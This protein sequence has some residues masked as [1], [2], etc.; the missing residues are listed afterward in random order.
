MKMKKTLALVMTAT[1]SFATLTGCSKTTNNY[2]DELAKKSEWKNVSSEVSGK[3]S[4]QSQ[5]ITKN[6]SFTSTG[7]V[8][9]NKGYANVKLTDESGVY[10]IPEINAYTDGATTYINKS[11]YEG[12]YTMMGQDVPEELKNIN[13]EYIAIDSGMDPEKLQAMATNTESMVEFTKLIFGD[14]DIDLPYVQNGNEYT[15]NLDSDQA[16]DL[17]VK[18]INAAAKNLDN[19]NE[20]FDLGLTSDEVNAIKNQIDTEEFTQGVTAVKDAIKGSSISMKEVFEDDKYTADFNVDIKIKDACNAN[21]TVN[22]VSTKAEEK[23]IAMPTSVAKI[24][25]EDMN[26]LH[27]Q[28]Q[29]ATVNNTALAKVIDE[30][31]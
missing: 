14:S 17:G 1:M 2:M 4:I 6:I 22:S 26:K 7:Y 3:F 9:N 16:V 29:E 23:D 31:A 12:I 13:A 27:A 11:Y 24:T 21:L 30:V 25:K 28:E 8:S 5:D 15:I 10:N 20:K 18:G 19:I